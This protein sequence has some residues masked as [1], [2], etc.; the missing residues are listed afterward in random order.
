ME[1]V[2][3]RVE[4]LEKN[5]KEI[6]ELIPKKQPSQIVNCELKEHQL[7]GFTWLEANFKEN[8]S[9]ILADDMGLGKTL[10]TIVSFPSFTKDFPFNNKIKSNM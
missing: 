1:K 9:S 10:T 8:C 2:L 7:E 5:T 6:L 3:E 4:K